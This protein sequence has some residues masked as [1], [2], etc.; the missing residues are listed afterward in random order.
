MR[1]IIFILTL[2]LGY[3]VFLNAGIMP[4]DTTGIIQSADTISIAIDQLDSTIVSY[5]DENRTL[6]YWRARIELLGMNED[7]TGMFVSMFRGELSSIN[8]V[9][10]SGAAEREKDY[11][12]QEFYLGKR[13]LSIQ[14]VSKAESRLRDIGYRMNRLRDISIDGDGKYHL[15]YMITKRPELNIDALAAFNQSAGADTLAFFGH[16]YL[17]VPNLDGKGKSL[18][19]NWQRLKSNSESFSLSYAH[20]WLFDLPIKA[21]FGFGREVVDGNYQNIQSKAGLEWTLNWERTMFFQ[22][23]DQ[24]SLITYEGSL[25][26]PEWKAAHRQLFGLGYK[27]YNLDKRLHRGFAVRTSL[28]QELEFEPSSLS[29]LD[30]RSEAE[31]PLF[32]HLYFSQRTAL[33]IQNKTNNE[34]DPSVLKPLGGVT[35]V[36]GYEENRYRSLSVASFQHDVY[37]ILGKQTRF[38]TLMDLGIYVDS[39]TLRYLGGYGLGVQLNSSRGP[40]RII[41]AKHQ[42]LSLQNSFLHIEYSGGISWIDR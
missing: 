39:E 37:Y 24:Q 6:G 36:R 3:C 31:I 19:L 35:S 20:P 23:E 5:M 29:R 32:R 21:V 41:L 2:H 14:D 40:I 15:N 1:H 13:M 12:N 16:I 30:F 28:S 7:S 10:F 18:S 33:S 27:Q 8:H 11:L 42:G 17:Y 26:Y 25:L 4:G 34:N 9:H 22:F 38:I